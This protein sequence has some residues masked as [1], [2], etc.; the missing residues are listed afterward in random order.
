[1]ALLGGLASLEQT[2]PCWKKV[3]TLRTQ[4]MPNTQLYL[5]PAD[6]DAEFSASLGPCLPAY[7]HAFF[8]DHNGL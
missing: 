3:A 5:L 4:A 7:C 1:M 6:E 8:H 2:W